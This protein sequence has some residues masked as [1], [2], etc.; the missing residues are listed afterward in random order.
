MLSKIALRNTNKSV[1]DYA[2]Y[3]FTLA[4]GVCIFYM[5]N[6]I[7][8]QQAMIGLTSR[9]SDSIMALTELLSYVSGFVAVVFG[10]LIVY[11]NSFFIKRRKKE[12]GI[13]MTLGME[14]SKISAI[15]L[16]ETSL[17]AVLAL[18]VGLVCGVILSHFMSIFT[19]RMFEANMEKFS[20]VFS[21][22]AAIKS[23]LYFGIIFFIV[24][25]FNMLAIS[26]FK[27]ID[28]IYGGRK[29]EKLKIRNT[30]ILTLIFILSM[31]ILGAAYYLIVTNG[32]LTPD[33][34]V[35]Y[36]I[37]LGCVGTVLFFFSLSGLLTTLIKGNKKIYYKNLNMFV[38]KQLGSK[39]N[40]NFI[41]ISIVSIVLLFT[42]G[43]FAT[44]YGLK[45]SLSKNLESAA[46]VDFSFYSDY[47]EGEDTK[48]N[49]I[50]LKEYL[51]KQ[52]GVKEYQT[53][54]VYSTEMYMNYFEQY[55]KNSK[56]VE[57]SKVPVTCV[58]LS[59]YNT[60]M[61]MQGK[62]TAS[63]NE[64]EYLMLS[65][66]DM[67]EEY[68]KDILDGNAPMTIY[69]KTLYP[70]GKETGSIANNY[71]T[72]LF[73]IPDN[74]TKLYHTSN[75]S[76][77]EDD[78]QVYIQYLN[79]NCTN[80]ETAMAINDY[81]ANLTDKTRPSERQEQ[82]GFILYDSKISLHE[83]SINSSALFS[84]LSLYLGVVF[85][86]TCAAILAIQQLTSAE[87]NK[88]RYSLLNKLGADKK[89]IHKA[90]FIQIMC[91][92]LFPLLLACVHSYFG[93][94][95]S[96]EAIKLYASI[97]ITSIVCLT[98]GFVLVLYGAYFIITY[99]SCK[100]I[101]DRT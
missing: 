6:S 27:L 24:I 67:M 81:F 84:F 25:V 50:G 77:A 59:D 72:L 29:N 35:T 57:L 17:M 58:S 40:T 18:I 82:M 61:K 52:D 66:V 9:Q 73:I 86:I 87:D 38:V 101:I 10:F 23:T 51:D 34:T 1:K 19:A 30:K 41:S 42:I 63:L 16:I 13:Y 92:F 60:S 97:N 33:N 95:A 94:T 45:D 71:Q 11:A 96:L 26:R 39:I 21:S 44:G 55:F 36:A 85:M 7:Y 46:V 28:L 79:V 65:S 56:D 2:I 69:G 68:A 83:E 31:G 48:E 89:M 99:V 80:E 3:F 47:V 14:K 70:A 49:F 43:I 32:M 75:A 15:L 78:H 4:L 64:D 54:S 8:A 22:S 98:A 5:F 76:N 62:K 90:L 20:F 93:L 12:M 53:I 37:I 91:Y 74:V 88:D 100:N